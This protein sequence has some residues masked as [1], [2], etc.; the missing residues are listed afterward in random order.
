MSGEAVDFELQMDLSGDDIGA[1]GGES[2]PP[3]PPG[4]YDFLLAEVEQGTS[5]AKQPVLKVTF[6]VL[7]EGEL[8]GK[9]MRKSYSLQAQSLGRVKNL[10]M[11]CGARLDA[12][13]RSELIGKQ[14]VAEVTHRQGDPSP[15]PDG[16]VQEGKMFGDIINE[17][18]PEG[19]EA[20]PE[21]AKEAAKP[22]PPPPAPPAAK[23]TN[24]RRAIGQAKA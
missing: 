15:M 6:E 10:M 23:A 8:L 21:P 19:D 4:V 22:A 14:I 7:N 16:S 3:L 1:W 24:V 17:R 20:Q 11:A 13:R 18:S 12:I 9:T 2:G 5:Q